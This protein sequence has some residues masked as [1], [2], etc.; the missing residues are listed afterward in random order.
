MLRCDP[1][2]LD[3]LNRGCYLAT[4]TLN[5]IDSP[6]EEL[7]DDDT[8]RRERSST[9]TDEAFHLQLIDSVHRNPCLYNPDDEYHGSKHQSA[10]F[11]SEIWKKIAKDIRWTDDIQGLQLVWKR[12]R[13]KFVRK[14]RKNSSLLNDDRH[15]N[16]PVFDAMRWLVPF[17]SSHSPPT[18]QAQ[19][20]D[21]Y[22]PHGLGHDVMISGYQ[23]QSTP[24]SNRLSNQGGSVEAIRTTSGS[25]SGYYLVRNPSG[26][27]G[28]AFRVVNSGNDMPSGRVTVL[29]ATRSGNGGGGVLQIQTPSSVQSN[30]RT[31]SRVHISGPSS[32]ERGSP[33]DVNDSPNLKKESS[34]S[35]VLDPNPHY[36]NGTQKMYR[37]VSATDNDKLNEWKPEIT[38]MQGL[39]RKR[40]L[41]SRGQGS[42]SQMG[43]EVIID[44]GIQERTVVIDQDDSD[45]PLLSESPLASMMISGH[46]VVSNRHQNLS[47]RVISSHLMQHPMNESGLSSSPTSHPG[48]LQQSQYDADLAFQQLISSS[49]ARY[50]DDMKALMKFNI[51]RI[52]LEARYGPGFCQRLIQEEEL[53][54]T[55]ASSVVAH[56]MVTK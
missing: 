32:F 29:P 53:T 36:Y 21:F 31:T 25:T 11:R 41:L 39:P 37:L 35:M 20:R 19:P 24:S 26:S 14:L 52:L 15:D 13:D 9:I 49:L 55:G 50:D 3:V 23:S 46:Q 17:I 2:I 51:Q 16:D 42:Q 27:G 6:L 48:Y 18:T 30:S 40:M 43:E 34:L 8:T 28:Q 12:L 44:D 10:E 45:S 47:Q 22:E 1:M 4:D 54:E 56:E 38:S 5:S 7:A 33:G